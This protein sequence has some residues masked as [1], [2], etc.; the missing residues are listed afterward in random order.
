MCAARKGRIS[1]NEGRTMSNEQKQKVSEGMKRRW[2]D[3][4]YRRTQSE[5]RKGKE[6]WNKGL[7]AQTDSRVRAQAEKMTKLPKSEAPPPGFRYQA[8]RLIQKRG[9]CWCCGETKK[10]LEVHHKNGNRQNCDES[11]LEV[12]C[13]SCHQRL[14]RFLIITNGLKIPP[15]ARPRFIKLVKL[16]YPDYDIIQIKWR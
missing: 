8:T 4:K 10:R 12:L 15:L 14:S 16:R 3:P 5:K 11:N 6:P 9:E 13:C 2:E 7:N 1:P